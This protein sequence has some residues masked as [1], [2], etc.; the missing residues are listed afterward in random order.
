MRKR[1]YID[2][3]IVGGYFDDEFKETTV[4][5][6][7]HLAEGKIIF[8]LSDLLELEL[9]RAPRKVR[10]LLLPFPEQSFE[11]VLLS[12][13]AIELADRYI[14]ERVVGKTSLGVIADTLQSQPLPKWMY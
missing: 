9:E 5:L 7:E 4:Q 13:E 1:L 3:S 14:E 12:N 6:F 2:T 10:E 8:V 11:R